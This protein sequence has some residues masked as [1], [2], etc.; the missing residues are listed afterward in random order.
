M[1]APINSHTDVHCFQK[2]LDVIE[3]WAQQWKIV[4]NVEKCQ[5]VNFASKYNAVAF[6]Y[7]LDGK[8]LATTSFKYLVLK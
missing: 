8:I 6:N 1:Y 2:S 3:K 5:A 7:N 4:F